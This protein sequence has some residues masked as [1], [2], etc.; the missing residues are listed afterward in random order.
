[1]P[2]GIYEH[3]RS[4]PKPCPNCGTDDDLN[5]RFIYNKKTATERRHVRCRE[6]ERR[7]V[8]ENKSWRNHYLLREYGI[9][10]FEHNLKWTEQNG[11]CTIC[12]LPLIPGKT[13]HLDHNHKTGQI[14]NLVHAQCNLFIAFIENHSN[15]IIPIQIYLDK[16][17]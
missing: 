7:K 9:S 15:L 1:M 8:N 5:F 4:E 11:I 13:T 12:N 3:K 14:R 2:Q 17:K 16:Y 6:C 10:E